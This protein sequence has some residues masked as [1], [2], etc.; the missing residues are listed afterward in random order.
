VPRS[1]ASVASAL[2]SAR[3]STRSR[4]SL[5]QSR[6]DRTRAVLI[7]DLEMALDEP[8]V[9]FAIVR[10]TIAKAT[11]RIFATGGVSRL[12]SRLQST[13]AD[14]PRATRRPRLRGSLAL[15]V[16]AAGARAAYGGL[17]E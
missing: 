15:R 16:A 12:E 13:S 14:P 3:R 5:T 17:L 11:K 9:A 6:R 10:R 1:S 4:P 2:G 7:A 8:L